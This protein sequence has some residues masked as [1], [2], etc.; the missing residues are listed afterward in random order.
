M[1][2]LRPQE[3]AVGWADPGLEPGKPDICNV[4]LKITWRQDRR[5]GAIEERLEGQDP[6][7]GAIEERIEAQN[8]RFANLE[9]DVAA[10]KA[11]V[12]EVLS[13]LPRS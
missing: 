4:R 8:R 1:G 13:R 10:I 3:D 6:R 9:S 11:A 12:A 2:E 5:L 7:L